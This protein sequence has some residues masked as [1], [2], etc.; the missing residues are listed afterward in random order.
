MGA[1]KKRLSLFILILLFRRV[2]TQYTQHAM[3][4]HPLDDGG[5]VRTACWRWLTPFLWYNYWHRTAENPLLIADL[6]DAPRDTRSADL[7]REFRALWHDQRDDSPAGWLE[8][9]EAHPTR[10][11]RKGAIADPHQTLLLEVDRSRHVLHLVARASLQPEIIAPHC[12][13]S[14]KRERHGHDD[15]FNGALCV[16]LLLCGIGYAWSINATFTIL[17]RL[18]HRLRPPCSRSS[19]TKPSDSTCRAKTPMSV[20]GPTSLQMTRCHLPMFEILHYPFLSTIFVCTVLGM[21]IRTVS[22]VPALCGFGT[23][24]LVR[25]LNACVARIGKRKQSMIAETDKR[26][27]SFLALEG[28]E[29]IKAWSLEPAFAARIERH[30]RRSRD[31]LCRSINRTQC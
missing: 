10:P 23:L 16:S 24:P 5:L 7:A 18:A 8:R 27:D 28:I 11:L 6:W 25:P 29:Q 22:L 1:S 12:R 15:R 17:V 19:S 21:M 30:R 20:R 9:L 4:P 31:T 26:T 2:E 13:A 14:D 3:A